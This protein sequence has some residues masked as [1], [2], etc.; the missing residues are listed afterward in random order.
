MRYKMM[1]MLIS[2]GQTATQTGFPIV[3]RCDI[4]YPN[5]TA[6]ASNEQYLHLNDTL[7]APIWVCNIVSRQIPQSN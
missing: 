6:A 2:A 4:M 1:P 7:V 3:V 5:H